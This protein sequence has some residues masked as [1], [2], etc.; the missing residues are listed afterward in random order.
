MG[1]VISLE[2]FKQQKQPLKDFRKFVHEKIL[3]NEPVGD[4]S[5]I[6]GFM[7]E[8]SLNPEILKGFISPFN[9]E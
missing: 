7:K 4:M 5:S 2:E 9:F 3:H 8:I 6:Y 1:K